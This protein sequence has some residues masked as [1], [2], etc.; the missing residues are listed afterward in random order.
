MSGP[1]RR[2]GFF[3]TMAQ[4]H[5]GLDNGQALFALY[6]QARILFVSCAVRVPRRVCSFVV[7]I[8]KK[9]LFELLV[10]GVCVQFV[11]V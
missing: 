2:A 6:G 8:L 11:L 4:N 9:N 5:D 10:T 3:R 1:D 7:L